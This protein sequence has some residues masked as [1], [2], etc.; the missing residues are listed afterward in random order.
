MKRLLIF[1]TICALC[2]ALYVFAENTKS[3]TGSLAAVTTGDE[4]VA[5][6][7]YSLMSNTI[8]MGNTAL[9]AYAGRAAVT[10]NGGLYLGYGAGVSN[11]S[12]HKLYINTMFYPSYGIFGD[13]STG[14]F[15]V[16]KTSPTVAFDVTG[17]ITASTTVTGT[18]GTFT[19]VNA[20]G[21][22]T[23]KRPIHSITAAA[24][25]FYTTVTP[26][27][28][29]APNCISG[30]VFVAQPMAQKSSLFLQGA[31][32]GLEFD[33]VVGDADSL[34]IVAA[35]GDSIYLAGTG[36]QSIGTVVGTAHVISTDAVR[37]FMTSYTGTWTLD[38][39]VQ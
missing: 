37:W 6:G 8:G 7:P 33:V 12:A 26:Y 14:Y 25:T 13:F 18:T 3:G 15:G 19:T 34:R 24:D 10:V 21:N 9:G 35:T 1:L 5:I 4:D 2:G 36:A 23:G 29:A 16:N 11:T 32:T 17:A 20:S 22:I 30:V 31:A 27:S 28:S 39:G 38:N